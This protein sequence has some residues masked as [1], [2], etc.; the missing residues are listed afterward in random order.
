MNKL[1]VLHY[2]SKAMLI[3]AALFVVPA[4]VGLIYSEYTC[5]LVF[6]AVGFLTIL[7]FLP[8]SLIKLKNKKMYARE[9]MVIASLIWIFYS[10]TGALPFYFSESIPDFL[11]ALFES[12]SVF[13]TTGATIITDIEQLPM[14]VTFWRS[15]SQWVGGMGVLV[16]AIAILPS[17]AD[18]MY[19]MQAECTGPSVNKL[20]PRGKK[21]AM[22]LYLIYT[23]MTV[24]VMV[25]LAGGG[26]PVFDSICYSMGTIGTGGLGIK[27]AGLRYYNS[28]YI[29][30]VIM[31]GMFFGGINFTLYY[32]ML[33]GRFKE[34][35]KNSELKV[36]TSIIII[37]S[38]LISINII[39]NYGNFFTALRYGTFQVIGMITSAGYSTADYC[40]WPM[41]SQII[42]MF[43]MFVGACSGSTGGGFKVQRLVILYKSATL[44]VRRM[45]HPNSVNIVKSDGKIIDSDSAHMVMRYLIIY[46]G[47]AA[48]SILFISLD[49][50][51]FGTTFSSAITCLNNIGPGISMVGPTEDYDFFSDRSKIVL[52]IDMLFGRLECLPLIILCSPSVWRKS[53]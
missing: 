19:L 31:M 10:I 27:N 40:N 50:V 20:V 24:I 28:F 14:S 22:Y 12:V 26:M 35:K 47:I 25:L 38:I 23:V 3:D 41:F 17:S 34:I 39:P 2:L 4:I 46:I 11:D 18:S 15:F 43:I 32:L 36:Y 8:L 6:L 29:E 1:L 33:T 51:D 30:T 49:D 42:I 44:S 37:A 21:S 52:M 7:I 5:S 16:F 53:F 13:T 45:L 9:G 48:G